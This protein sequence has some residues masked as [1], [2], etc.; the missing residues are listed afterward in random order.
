MATLANTRNSSL[1]TTTGAALARGATAA[2]GS[3]SPTG[4]AM[5][6]G[7]TPLAIGFIAAVLLLVYWDR[8]VVFKP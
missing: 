4:W 6:V 7:V 1:G 3:S 8:R 5:P 2:P